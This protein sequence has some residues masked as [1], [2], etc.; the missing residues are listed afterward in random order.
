MFK[1]GDKIKFNDYTKSLIN[2]SNHEYYRSAIWKSVEYMIIDIV[3]TQSYGARCFYI[4][5]LPIED[6]HTGQPIHE[7][8]ELY[9]KYNIEEIINDLNNLEQ[10]LNGKLV[11]NISS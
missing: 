7:D 2:A 10:K 4:N 1:V 8:I 9:I 5:G 3:R 11:N 6:L